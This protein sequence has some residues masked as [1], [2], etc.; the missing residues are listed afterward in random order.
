M[1]Q[2]RSFWH[3]FSCLFFGPERIQL[4]KGLNFLSR[5][6]H[7]KCWLGVS[8]WPQC[9]LISSFTFVIK[10]MKL[11]CVGRGPLLA[12]LQWNKSDFRP[13]HILRIQCGDTGL[14]HVNSVIKIPEERA[15][16]C[17]AYPC[18]GWKRSKSY[19]SN[20]I[21]SMCIHV[22]FHRIRPVYTYTD[23][24]HTH[25]PCTKAKSQSESKV[26]RI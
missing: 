22:Y 1:K 25:A 18:I 7:V 11:R 10:A 20:K 24:D 19:Q 17:Y 26:D 12:Y 3:A 21:H 15:W 16:I 13:V 5:W 14:S 23:S 8:W 2:V 4:G 6:F 9:K